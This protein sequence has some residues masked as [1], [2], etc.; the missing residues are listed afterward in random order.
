M[1][2]ILSDLTAV[3]SGNSLS[4]LSKRNTWGKL[5]KESQP[6]CSVFGPVNGNPNCEIAE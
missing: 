3:T 2:I 5:R 4:I 1:F 6:L